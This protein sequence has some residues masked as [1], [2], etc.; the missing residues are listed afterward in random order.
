MSIHET[1][2]RMTQMFSAF[3]RMTYSNVQTKWAQVCDD[4][5]HCLLCRRGGRGGGYMGQNQS[6]QYAPPPSQQV[7]I[8]VWH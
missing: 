7:R 5:D 3:F 2:R 8:I 4:K 6:N 1:A